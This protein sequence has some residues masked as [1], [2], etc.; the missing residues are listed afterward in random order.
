MLMSAAELSPGG[1]LLERGLVRYAL[2]LGLITTFFLTYRHTV[3][4]PRP[5]QH[6]ER[7]AL[8]P[9]S[10]AVWHSIGWT[11]FIAL[12]L[13]LLLAPARPRPVPSDRP[14]RRL[15]VGALAAA[16]VITLWSRLA[17]GRTLG[18]LESAGQAPLAIAAVIAL[19]VLVGVLL[20]PPPLRW[21]LGSF[22]LAGVL[23]RLVLYA[24]VTPDAGFSDNLPAIERSLERLR[25]GLTPYAI[26][27]FGS[28][29]NPMPYLPLTFLVYLPAQLIGLDIRL[30]NLVLT[31]LL[32]LGVWRL[33][34]ALPLAATARAGLALLTG[35]LYVLPERLS[36]DVYNE[37][38]LFTL[39]LVLTFGLVMLGRIRAA[40]V[41][42]GASLAAMPVG[43]F[44]ALPLLL[45]ALR[46]R[47]PRE[48]AGL[49]AIIGLVGG[50]PTL[51]FILWDAEAFFG[52]FLF[53]T[54]GLWSSLARGESQLPLLLWHGWLGGGLL[55]VQAALV[56]A[57]ALLSWLRLR[58]VRGLIGLSAMLYI[59]LIVTGP[60][61]AQYMATVVLYLALLAEAAAAAGVT[62]GDRV[63]GRIGAG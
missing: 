44:V 35:L 53:G 28:H 47:P 54:T 15:A 11:I 4:L 60:H 14:L 8:L 38:Q 58:T 26:H 45:L 6:P 21:L 25:A 22:L 19:I 2:L 55:A 37:W 57:V 13:V 48:V 1:R 17:T 30:T 31:T 56:A 10:D 61:I 33:L 20:R 27:D 41:A 34:W 29:T 18:P 42:Y 5:G 32:T 63:L 46:S 62:E 12:L 24:V 3:W 7:L 39:L 9:V 36:K 23:L 49:V 40:A 43:F 59:G 16:Y 52:A 50:L 51:L